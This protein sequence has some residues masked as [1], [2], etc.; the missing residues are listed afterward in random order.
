MTQLKVRRNVIM[1]ETYG[2]LLCQCSAPSCTIDISVC[3][4]VCVHMFV[5]V[6]VCV[7]VSVCFSCMY[8]CV[9]VNA[10]R[11]KKNDNIQMGM[12]ICIR[13]SYLTIEFYTVLT[14]IYST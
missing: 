10:L 5:C 8:V 9:N 11:N 12:I 4:C 3:A 14:M 6:C 13:N 2:L 1:D 7:C